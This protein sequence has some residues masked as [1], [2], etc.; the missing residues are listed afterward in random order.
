MTCTLPGGIRLQSVCDA[1]GTCF[2]L[3]HLSNHRWT[4]GAFI[5]APS[6]FLGLF[7][8]NRWKQSPPQQGMYPH[9]RSL[10]ERTSVEVHAGI[11]ITKFKYLW[12]LATNLREKCSALC[13]NLLLFSNNWMKGHC[14]HPCLLYCAQNYGFHRTSPS[15]SSPH[16]S[17][18]SF[19]LQ[20]ER[21]SLITRKSPELKLK[22]V[23][24]DPTSTWCCSARVRLSWSL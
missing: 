16:L 17:Y 7:S 21:A 20:H 6:G 10:F 8:R 12:R 18:L 3:Q 1:Y 9:G 22:A 15:G 13:D 24:S 11:L 19:Q 23:T 14:L 2:L 4:I 5:L